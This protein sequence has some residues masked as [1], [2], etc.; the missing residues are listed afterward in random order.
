V[1]NS[2]NQSQRKGQPSAPPAMPATP[3][4]GQTAAAHHDAHAG[5]HGNHG[6]HEEH[7]SH[8]QKLYIVIGTILAVLTAI[9]VGITFIGLDQ[10]L[11][12]MFLMVLM[13]AK[14]LLVVLFFMHLKFDSRLFGV[15]FA[16]PLLLLAVPMVI[17]FM[18][19]FQNHVGLAG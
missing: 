13:V 2:G 8:G 11:L 3:A 18:L 6:G 16:V 7:A 4:A 10:V 9:E 17:V 12:V 19:L 5:Q 15:L 1:A 14:G